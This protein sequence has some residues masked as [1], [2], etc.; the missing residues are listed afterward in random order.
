MSRELAKLKTE[1]HRLVNNQKG[2]KALDIKTDE[3]QKQFEMYKQE[4]REER[5]KV[6]NLSLWKSQLSEKNKELREENDRY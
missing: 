4:L 1:N 6:T 3:S 5:E 2:K